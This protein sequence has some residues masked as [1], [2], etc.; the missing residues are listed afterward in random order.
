MKIMISEIF[1]SLQG[2]GIQIGI[3]TVFV[4][5]FGCDLRCSWCDSMYAVEG[6]DFSSLEI[7]VEGELRSFN[8]MNIKRLKDVGAFRGLR[9][10]GGLPANGQRTKT[11]ART[12]KG[13]KRTIGLGKK[14]I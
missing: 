12:R 7:N 11:N 3:P 9:H 1:Y 14:A 13:K 2:E 4:R 8:A 5:L 6:T 10:R